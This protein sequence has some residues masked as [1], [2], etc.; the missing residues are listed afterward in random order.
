MVSKFGLLQISSLLNVQVN[1]PFIFQG[2]YKGFFL[3]TKI[4]PITFDLQARKQDEGIDFVDEMW[5]WGR[6]RWP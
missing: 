3:P 6:K 5:R 4:D 1:Q 2:V